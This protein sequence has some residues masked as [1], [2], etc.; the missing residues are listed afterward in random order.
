MSNGFNYEGS[1][2]EKEILN[3]D[4]KLECKGIGSSRKRGTIKD[5]LGSEKPTK[6]LHVQESLKVCTSLMILL[7]RQ[8]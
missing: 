1:L 4:C 5:L 2:R 3:E 8:N 6:N 7:E